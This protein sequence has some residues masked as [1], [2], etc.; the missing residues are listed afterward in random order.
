MKF[1]ELAERL[2]LTE[3]PEGWDALYE[4]VR[5]KGQPVSLEL[6]ERLQKKYEMFGEYYDQVVAGWIDT[7]KKPERLAFIQLAVHQLKNDP[8]ILNRER[9]MAIPRPV[10][11]NTP[12]GDMMLL[13]VQVPFLEQAMAQYQ[14]RGFSEEKA[15]SELHCIVGAMN[16]FRSITG[17]GGMN[18]TYFGWTSH[19][20]TATIFRHLG[21]N[22]E[23]KI[24]PS[25]NILILK[26]K[27]TGEVLPVAKSL[28]VHRSGKLLGSLGYEDEAGSFTTS[29]DENDRE[30]R[31]HAIREIAIEKEPS[32]FSKSEWEVAL[33]HGDTVLG[34]HIPR[35]TDLSPE[36]VERACRSAEE[37]AKEQFAEWAP[38][39]FHCS[40]WLLS[41]MIEPLMGKE[42]NISRFGKLF[43]RYPT[44]DTTA[45]NGFSFL[46]GHADANRPFEELP[47]NSSLQR[48]VKQLYLDGGHLPNGTGVILY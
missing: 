22:F 8:R 21:F 2:S 47:E 14:A 11:D 9:L 27:L 16:V 39:A 46:Y 35:G 38:K 7:L 12:A 30:I 1:S 19:Y 26:N 45:R 44:L 20:M 40:S 3:Y 29:F 48:A 41:P 43:T 24:F 37:I 10:T 23:F 18:P 32:V 34:I 13:F 33:K 6:L 42:T 31:A 17:R 28:L 36:A 15:K 5:G 4:E 25:K